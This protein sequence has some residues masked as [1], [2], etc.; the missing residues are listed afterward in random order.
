MWA[1]K[2]LL[3]N[4]FWVILMCPG[5]R[6]GLEMHRTG[7]FLNKIENIF[8]FCSSVGFPL[9]ETILSTRT[10]DKFLRKHAYDGS[11]QQTSCV[12]KN[13]T[14]STNF[15]RTFRM[16][17]PGVCIWAWLSGIQRKST[18]A[19]QNRCK[20]AMGELENKSKTYGIQISYFLHSFSHHSFLL[21]LNEELVP[22]M[23]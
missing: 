1:L 6:T 21:L 2:D 12:F 9:G 15:A 20:R 7:I 23:V 3:Q 22:Q 5:H 10:W 8:G 19:A 17:L 16:F 4:I 14:S 18:Y 11:I 13:Q